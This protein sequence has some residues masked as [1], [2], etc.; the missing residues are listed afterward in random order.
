MPLK[1][2]FLPSKASCPLELDLRAKSNSG[3]STSRIGFSKPAKTGCAGPR[4]SKT[5]ISFFPARNHG[6]GIYAVCVGPIFQNRAKQSA[7]D[8]NHAFTPGAKIEK[9]IGGLSHIE[10]PAPKRRAARCSRFPFQTGQH[11]LIEPQWDILATYPPERQPRRF[12]QR[13]A[14]GLCRPF[15][16]WISLPKFT[17]PIASTRMSSFAGFSRRKFNRITARAAIHDARLFAIE[18]HPGKVM[19]LLDL[20][21]HSRSGR[22]LGAV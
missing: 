5:T 21:F 16:S 9:S 2:G 8:P 4:R 19:H 11:R 20:Q 6:P 17:W 22:K 7:V 3:R 10:C 18:K 12:R 15:R 1:I 14:P 13:F